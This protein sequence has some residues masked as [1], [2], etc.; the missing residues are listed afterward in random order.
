MI[1]QGDVLLVPLKAAHKGKQIKPVNGRLVLAV[2]EATGHN[3]TI[4]AEKATMFEDKEMVWIVA[5]APT[6]LVHQ[7]H[8]SVEVPVGTWQVVRQREYTPKEI[9]RV[10]D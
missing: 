6:P 4:S 3:H 7:E 1:R 8:A 5:E 10:R 2:G 9:V